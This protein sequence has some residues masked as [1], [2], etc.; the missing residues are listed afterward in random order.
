MGEVLVLDVE[1]TGLSRKT[2]V[3]TTACWYYKG[4]W[5]RWVRDLDSPELFKSHWMESDV[6][7]TFNGRN[8]DEKFVIKDLGLHQHENH[9]DVMHDGWR[10]GYKG[11][12]KSV[13]ESIGL[14]RPPEIQGMDG[15]AAI[16][17]W[18]SWSSGDEEA[19]ELLSLYNAWDVWLTRGLYQKF[20]LNQNP[21]TE[22]R[23]PWRL[24]LK[25]ACRLLGTPDITQFSE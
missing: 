20:V 16:T 6:L 23:I 22:H 9:R 13:S 1:T 19:L 14:P 15:R 25:S 7:V 12:L 8:F 2:D 4:E 17:L 11:G 5:N 18:E 10:L 21:E 3:I 24:D